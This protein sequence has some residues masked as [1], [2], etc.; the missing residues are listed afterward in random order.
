MEG[1]TRRRATDRRRRR[2]T[3]QRRRRA[4]GLVGAA[5]LVI[6][7]V[8]GAGHDEESEQ[9]AGLPEQCTGSKPNDLRRIVGM[10]LVVRWDGAP[11]SGLEQRI[12][13][14]EVGGVIVFPPAGGLD[15][16]KLAAAA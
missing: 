5:A 12:R 3:A 13:H 10:K 2:L 8:V 6:G 15:P 1:R 7:I 11:S 9:K 4:L 14:D 16:D